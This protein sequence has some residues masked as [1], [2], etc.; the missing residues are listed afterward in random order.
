MDDNGEHMGKGP[1]N[2]IRAEKMDNECSIPASRSQISM[3]L[4]R[5]VHWCTLI[6]THKHFVCVLDN[7]ILGCNPLIKT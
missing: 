3:V 1:V 5:F 6:I 2:P 4:S 7:T